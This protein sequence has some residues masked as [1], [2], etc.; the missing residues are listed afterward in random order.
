MPVESRPAA[1]PPSGSGALG[2][3]LIAV[4]RI[5]RAQGLR[6][7]VRLAPL[8][9]APER[10]GDLRQCWLVPPAAGEARVIETLRFHGRV[11]ILKLGGTDAVGDAEAL[12]G[13][14]VA[15]PRTDAR[16]L[17]PDR[18]YAFDLVGCAVETPEGASLGR[19]AEVLE[20]LAHDYWAVEQDRRR[21]L[22]PAVSAFVERVDVPGRRVVVRPPEGLVEL[23]G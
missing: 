21:W 23:D 5:V 8:T 1:G 22:L 14:L 15:I 9:D 11:P 10:L 12:V 4:A 13:R 2:G 7:E 16:P 6:G 18:F 17:P 20:G 3:P 19:I